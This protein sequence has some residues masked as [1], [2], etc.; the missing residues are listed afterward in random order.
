MSSHPAKIETVG[1]DPGTERYRSLFNNVPVAIWEEDISGV[2]AMVDEVLALGID[3]FASWLD[4]H[5]DFVSRALDAV[6]IV[7]VNEHALT[8]YGADSREALI[9]HFY[10]MV[11]TPEALEVF[12]RDLLALASGARQ[13]ETE[14]SVQALD[15]QPL[16]MLVRMYLPEE[17]PGRLI[18]MELDITARKIAEDRLR[19]VQRLDAVGQLT[20]GIAHDFNNLLTV[21]LGNVALLQESL[22]AG[23]EERMLA[24]QVEEA[25][26]R[27]AELTGQLLAFA[28]KQPLQPRN[29]DVDLVSRN[30]QALIRGML[31]PE[32]E[33]EYTPSADL[34]M[35]SVDP[36]QLEG[37]LMNLALNA[38]DAMPAGG[39]LSIETR[40]HTLA[41]PIASAEGLI[42]AG[43]YVSIIV[44][45]T[46]SGMDAATA[47]RAVEPFFTTKAVGEGSGL[48]LSMVH[49][50][51]H[52][53]GG[54]MRITS[55]PGAGTCIQLD[56]P[57]AKAEGDHERAAAA[58]G[59]CSGRR[60]SA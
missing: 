45:D 6:R 20:G 39:R 54:Y 60:S 15:G 14:Y 5:P 16:H 10:Q 57:R 42:P 8:L 18:L 59:R 40:N 33:F 48:G 36:A 17:Q 52:Q 29:V 25:A 37:A 35:A 44:A 53:S 32:I 4:A 58:P 47:S 46:G 19:H 30:L 43:D 7:D 26:R 2:I 50:F 31:T 55:S 24:A 27:G 3:D 41:D 22:A 12:K 1:A 21:V 28:R 23:S 49:G 34:W 13:H 38:R 11:S 51:V 56:L 9:G